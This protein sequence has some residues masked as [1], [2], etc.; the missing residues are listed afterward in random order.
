MT[1]RYLTSLPERLLR[2]VAAVTGG[3]VYEATEIL[4]PDWLRRSHVYAALIGRLLRFIVESMGGVKHVFPPDPLSSTEFITRKTTGNIVEL[5]GSFA[6]G[7]WSP[8][9]LLA[10]AADIT[11]GTK[12]YLQAFVA[13]LQQSG[14][15]PRQVT[16][17]SVEELL[18]T[19]EHLSGQAADAIDMPPLK[20]ADLRAS[21]K[22]L[23]MHAHELPDA[24]SLTR[25]YTQLREVA[26]REGRSMQGIS[27]RI[28]EGALT[29]GVKLGNV[30]LF[31]Y[32][33]DA[34]RS[35]IN[36]GLPSFMRRVVRPYGKA[37][38]L[39]F[40]PRTR[41]A[42]ERLLRYFSSRLTR[43]RDI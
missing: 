36:E 12:V 30:Y 24:R 10:A 7:G 33:R 26:A 43:L 27:G 9:W 34:L 38:V 35:I 13:E 32:Y 6:L 17:Q 3:V 23:K 41:T 40:N 42:T 22:E 16:I 31:D 21:W 19:L 4:L 2:A 20:P 15:L 18:D 25:L 11:G 39:H 37:V 8:L 14:V 28:A 1:S 5:A 29:A